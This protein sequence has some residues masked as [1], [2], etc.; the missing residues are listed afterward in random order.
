MGAQSLIQLG[1]RRFG[2][3]RRR[4]A[5]GLRLFWKA[6][7]SPNRAPL[8]NSLHWGPILEHR[9]RSAYAYA[10][11]A[12]DKRQAAVAKSAFSS[13]GQPFRPIVYS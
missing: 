7:P 6:W 4:L 12:A 3:H 5:A 10:Y 1:C 9:G 8:L 13:T 11:A 2:R